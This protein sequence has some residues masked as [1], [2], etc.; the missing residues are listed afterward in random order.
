MDGLGLGQIL[1]RH[2]LRL[3]VDLTAVIQTGFDQV[4]DYFLLAINGDGPATRQLEHIDAVTTLVEAQ[5]DS[6]VN[7]AFAP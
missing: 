1:Q 5:F 3:E 4:F 7:Q 2:C 6:M